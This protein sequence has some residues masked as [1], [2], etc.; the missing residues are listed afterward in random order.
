MRLQIHLILEA[1]N[2]AHC[3]ALVLSAFGCG[4]FGNPPWTVA[5]LFHEAFRTRAGE[6]EEVVFCEAAP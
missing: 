2:A 6:L 4:A 5:A 1:A 3:D